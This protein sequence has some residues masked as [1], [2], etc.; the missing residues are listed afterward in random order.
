MEIPNLSEKVSDDSLKKGI[1]QVVDVDVVSTELDAVSDDLLE[2]ERHAENMSPV[3]IEAVIHRI[4]DEHGD[5]PNFPPHVLQA[6]TSYLSDAPP[7]ERQR[8]YEILKVQAALMVIN[9]PYAEVRAIVSNHDDPSLPTN[10]FRVWVLGSLFVAAGAFLN[11]FFS[12][13]FPNIGIGPNVAQ[14]LVVPLAKLMEMLPSTTFTTFG[15]KWSLN[16]SPFNKK[17]TCSLPSWPMLGSVPLTQIMQVHV[18]HSFLLTIDLVQII[19]V[20]Y[21]N[22][23]FNQPWAASFGYQ[24][25]VALSTS[26]IGYG[27]A[28]LTRRFLVYPA[29]AIWQGNLGAI[30]LNSAF[31]GDKNPIANGWRM[32]RLRWFFYCFAAMFVYFWFPDYIFQALSIFNWITWISP[33]NVNVAAITGSITG[34]G[35]NPIPTFDW[36]QVTAEV[37]PLLAPFFTTMN[38][39]M[40]TL[41]SLPIIAALWYTNTWNT[42]YLSINTNHVFDNTG[43]PYDIGQVIGS[44]NL[45]N[46]TM[47]EQYSPAYLS[48]SNSLVYGVFF[49]VYTATLVHAFLYHRHAIVHG[50]KSL[51]SRKKPS[52]M[53]QDVHCRL[54]EAYEEV[55]EWQYFIV[56]VTAI[57]LGAVGV[58]VYPTHTS[59]AVVLFGVVLA[60]IF[61]IPIG[62]IASVANVE[63]PLNVLAEMFGGLWFPGNAIAMNYFKAYGLCTTVGTI[64]FASDLKL[65]HYMHISPKQTFW[66]QIHA[67]IISA[68]VCTAILNFQMT[69]ITGVCTPTQPDK[70]TCPGINTFFTASVIWG[71]LGPKRMFGP[72]GTYNHLLWFFL[73]GAIL[74]IPIYLLRKR[75][76]ALHYF[77]LPIFLVGALQ[78]APLSMAQMW[79]AVPVGWFFNYFIKRR[80]L[81]WWSKYNYITSTAFSAA[82]AISGVLIFFTVQYNDVEINWSGNTKLAEGCDAMGCPRLPLP[83]VGFFGPGPGEFH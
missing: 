30:A 31:H 75:V 64:G 20:Q 51:L 76:K 72:G 47:Y 45:F 1:V 53:H 57:I 79:P 3:E 10:T 29:H 5:D 36:N 71:L 35:L 55:P 7:A 6:A 82:I 83:D 58:G 11:Q 16:P 37:D 73:I 24:V 26:L 70:F 33:M 63:I 4:L 59:P 62:I 52:D 77:H 34:L 2:A 13:R 22:I 67:T 54:M 9:S 50:F 69:K 66:F 17:N 12:I 14:I 27:L 8:L 38:V 49:A 68:F 23:Y 56:L 15:Y 28:G 74:P 18:W 61:V 81:A 60:L 19:M 25:L 65:A 39:F 80:Y 40:G 42:G 46:Q 43:L 44:D 21:L 41:V 78:W 32:T 48:A